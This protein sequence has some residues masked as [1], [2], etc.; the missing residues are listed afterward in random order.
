M[1]TIRFAVLASAA[2]FALLLAACG[3]TDPAESIA[4]VRHNEQGQLDSIAGKDLVGAVRLYRDDARL[5]RPDGSVLDGGE[6]IAEAYG[7]MLDDPNFAL[8]IEPLDGWASADGDM[9]VV[10]S[11]VSITATDPATGTALT[12]P[13]TSQTVWTRENGAGWKIVSAFNVPAEPAAAPEAVAS[14]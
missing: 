4:A 12:A 8:T 5:V 3:S 11:A 6:A 10:T 13:L 1:K 9:A 14:Q 2:P 7:D